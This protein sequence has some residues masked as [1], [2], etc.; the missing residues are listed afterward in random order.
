MHASEPTFLLIDTIGSSA[1]QTILELAREIVETEKQTDP[2]EERDRAKEALT[3]LF[4]EA[5][6]RTPTFPSSAS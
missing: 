2:V 5:K 4:N 1:G 6:A 3:D